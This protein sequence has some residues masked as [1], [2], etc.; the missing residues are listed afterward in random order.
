MESSIYRPKL[1]ADEIRRLIDLRTKRQPPAV[2]ATQAMAQMSTGVTGGGGAAGSGGG[3]G[4]PQQIVTVSP[5]GE[6]DHTTIQAAIDGIIDATANKRYCV[7][8]YPGRYNEAITLTSFISIVGF[9]DCRKSVEIYHNT[10]PV[11]TFPNDA[12]NDAALANLWL[13]LTPTTDNRKVVDIPACSEVAIVN[14]RIEA[15]S[16]TNAVTGQLI[17]HSD[18]TLRLVEDEFVY[19]YSGSAAGAQSHYG[20]ELNGSVTIYI[21]DC[22]FD[23]LVGDEDDNS[24]LIY[25]NTSATV[26]SF[27]KDNNVDMVLSHGAPTGT[28]HFYQA[29]GSGQDK[30]VQNN[31]IYVLLAGAANGSI[32]RCNSLAGNSEVNSVGNFYRIEGGAGNY[33]AYFGAGD[34][35]Y[36]HFDQI[37]AVGGHVGAGNYEF[38]NSPTPG[39]TRVTGDINPDTDGVYDLGSNNNERWE[40]I[41]A[42]KLFAE[43]KAGEGGVAAYCLYTR[44][45]AGAGR[46]T[47]NIHAINNEPDAVGATSVISAYHT[48][49][50]ASKRYLLDLQHLT[51]NSDNS[52][53]AIYY[54]RN[55]TELYHLGNKGWMADKYYNGIAPVV[56]GAAGTP[57][58]WAVAFGAALPSIQYTVT[59]TGGAD[60]AQMAAN[61]GA[62]VDIHTSVQV[63]NS[64][65]T[66]NGFTGF[67]AYHVVDSATGSDLPLVLAGFGTTYNNVNAMIAAL[68]IPP[69]VDAALVYWQVRMYL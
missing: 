68:G 40:Q 55:G 48:P 12:S 26:S 10:G 17:D 64:S 13:N 41:Q 65:K 67:I 56:P 20:I 16:A 32:L 44:V 4:S 60:L 45:N 11:I 8:V 23:Y 2:S 24:Y 34:T 27:I 31:R 14:C 15:T 61:Y 28:M 3:I 51:N 69:P 5:D 39:E 57:D 49:A 37:E 30:Y 54:E 6:A 58:A 35:C 38:V 43:L 52:A 62:P 7:I 19:A 1:S 53:D 59:A 21:Q 33:W 9:C 29:S 50:S 18:G 63:A 47:G 36:S 46:L 22:I 66:V 25:E 42:E